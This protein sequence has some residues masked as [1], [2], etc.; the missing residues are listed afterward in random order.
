MEF[1]SMDIGCNN[2]DSMG[3]SDKVL[4]GQRISESIHGSRG[5]QGLRVER[6]GGGHG[7]KDMCNDGVYVDVHVLDLPAFRRR[8]GAHIFAV[9]QE[10]QRVLIRLQALLCGVGRSGRVMCICDFTG[11]MVRHSGP[12]PTWRSR[13][14]S[15]PKT[16]DC[17]LQGNFRQSR[18][19]Q[20]CCF[21]C[22]IVRLADGM[23][24]RHFAQQ[25]HRLEPC[26]PV[27]FS[28]GPGSS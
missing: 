5:F 15:S 7:G 20:A 12:A 6:G 13:P 22:N 4:H 11:A 17:L 8:C 28:A 3:W 16:R 9:S 24:R 19:S 21:S 25:I 26:F 1:G 18:E 23:S 10:A 2:K 14:S 27:C